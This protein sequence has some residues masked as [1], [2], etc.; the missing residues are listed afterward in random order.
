MIEKSTIETIIAYFFIHPTEEIHLRELSRRLQLSMPTILSF[1]K[2]LEKKG[3]ILVHKGIALTTVKANVENK[4]FVRAK[5]V[6][7]LQS[8]YDS[9]IVDVLSQSRPD[10]II[11]FGS[12]S[13]G[14][15]TER[16]DIDLAV[17]KGKEQKLVVEKYEKILQRK[18]SLHFISLEK[19]S[20]E[21]KAN[22]IN[23]II[24]EGAV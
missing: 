23:G 14:E 15:D 9:G 3:L 19:I 10:A 11:C 4:K 8:I 2:I 13:R 12:Y 20:R 21:F 18:I 7:N 6:Y 5:R 22:L 24:L 17:V 1:V 16:S